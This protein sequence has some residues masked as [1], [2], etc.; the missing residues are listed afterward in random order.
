MSGIDLH[1]HSTAS[2]GTFSPWEL[3]REAKR[4]DLEAIAV[5]DHDTTTGLK[6]AVQAGHEL[7]IEVIPGCELSLD[8]SPGYMHLIGLWLPQHPIKLNATLQ[9]LR[10]KRHTRN[11]QIIAKLQNLGIDISYEQ[12]KALAGQASV[13]RPHI[14]RI[15]V[16]KG[17]VSSLNS[18]FA[19]YLGKSAKAYAP[20]EKLTPAEAIQVLKQ[21]QAT[22]ILAH[23]YS[24]ALNSFDLQKEIKKLKKLGLNG[25]EVYY[26]GH[27]PEQKR[28]FLQLS[29][30]MDLLPSGGSDFHGSVK[31]GIALGRGTGGLYVPYE[32]L[33]ALKKRRQD[34]GLWVTEQTTKN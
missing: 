8:Y 10:A 29:S 13:G 17:V 3:V 24:L 2:D 6:E 12:V 27:T 19:D 9:D 7:G 11:K 23:P 34:K 5:T 15:L 32:L 22:I 25:I 33:A 1:T 18:A 31:P 16:Q 26:P 30:K 20:K 14:A 4:K 28:I 21:E